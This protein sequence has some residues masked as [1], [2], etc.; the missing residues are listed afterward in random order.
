GSQQNPTDIELNDEII[1]NQ[2]NII[3]SEYWEREI[4]EWKEMLAEEE[5]F[6]LEEKEALRELRDHWTI[7]ND[8][9]LKIINTRQLI[10]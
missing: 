7:L 9:L 5:K 4:N 2:S 1:G 8:D 6:R 3:T 10:K